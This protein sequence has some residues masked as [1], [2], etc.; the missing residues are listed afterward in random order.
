VRQDDREVYIARGLIDRFDLTAGDR[1]IL[2]FDEDRRPWV[3][4]ISSPDTETDAPG[5]RVAVYHHGSGP[6]ARTTSSRVAMHLKKYAPEDGR[7]RLYLNGDTETADVEGHSV[8]LH[9]LT[10]EHDPSDK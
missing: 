4:F 7:G 10:P 2:A 6:D 1:L 5:A 8:R 9:R 3:G